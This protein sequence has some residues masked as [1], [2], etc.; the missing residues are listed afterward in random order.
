MR[1]WRFAPAVNI[2]HNGRSQQTDVAQL[3]IP[4]NAGDITIKRA[5]ARA[6]EVT[7]LELLQHVVERHDDGNIT[8]RP[9]GI[10]AY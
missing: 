3:G 5:V 10:C 2:R 9:E 1:T 4:A 8:V 6:L 7:T